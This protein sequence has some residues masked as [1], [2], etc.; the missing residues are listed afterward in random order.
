M[1]DTVIKLLPALLGIAVGYILRLRGV[2]EHRDADFMFRLIINVFLPALAFTALSRVSIGRD[3]GIF[4]LAALVIIAVGYLAGRLLASKGPFLTAQQAVAICCCMNVNSGF[5]LPFV[6]GLYGVDGVARIAAFDAVNTTLMFT[7]TAAVAARGNP[8]HAGGSVMAKRFATSPPLYAIAAGLLVSAFGVDVPA[9]IGD[10]LAVLGA[11]TGILMAVAVG[12]QF[13]PPGK[14]V[15]KAALVYAGR[16]A[17][18]VVVAVAFVLIFGL[19]GADRTVLLL[20]AVGPTP[21]F[22]VAFA[23]TENLDV[24]L[25]VNTVSLSMLVSLPLTIGVIFLTT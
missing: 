3:L 1:I 18:A 11:P 23:T 9:A 6:Q 13:E 21:F 19:T 4:P 16:L 10:P 14:G 8:R 22:V 15:A 20:L 12:I 5:I 24:R 17:S 25:T 2:A 7:W